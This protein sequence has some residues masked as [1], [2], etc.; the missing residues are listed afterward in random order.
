MATPG[1]WIE[2]YETQPE[3]EQWPIPQKET[4]AEPLPE[5]EPEETE[6]E[7]RK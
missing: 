6:K 5:F 4:E 7:A 2:E 1:K 3:P